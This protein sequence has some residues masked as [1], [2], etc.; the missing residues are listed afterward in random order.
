[1]SASRLPPIVVALAALSHAAVA[2]VPPSQSS[3]WPE[4]IEDNSFLIEEAYNQEPGVVQFISAAV[5]AQPEGD[6]LATFTNEWP[7]PGEAHQLSFTVPYTFGS[8]RHPTSAGDILLNYRYQALYEESDGVAFA[9]RLTVSLPTGDRA[10]GLGMGVTGYQTELPFSKRLTR[11]LAAHLNLGAAYWPG[12]DAST[13]DQPGRRAT[14][15]LLNEGLSAIWL[16][17]PRCNLMLEAV[18]YQSRAPAGGATAW[19]H[20]ALV[21]PGLRYA[22]NL[23]AGQLVVGA[24]AP[25]GV[26]ASSPDP[27]VLLYLSWEM[28]VWHPAP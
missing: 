2:Q 27:S 28:P 19:T 22:F 18:A 24:A 15:W 3:A 26:T 5:R 4:A 1:M 10:D 14:E 23:P 12:V 25:I 17:S 13:A 8:D 21:S 7:A 16:I 9:P 6:W 11:G 20:Q